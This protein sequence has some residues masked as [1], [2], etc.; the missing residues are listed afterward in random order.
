MYLGLGTCV[1][2]GVYC[3][4]KAGW[5]SYTHLAVFVLACERALI[6][7]V[8]SMTTNHAL[9]HVFFKVFLVFFCSCTC[10]DSCQSSL[11]QIRT[12][13]AKLIYC[14]S[15]NN[16]DGYEMP[17]LKF[18]SFFRHNFVCSQS[19]TRMRLTTSRYSILFSLWS[20]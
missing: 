1:N 8:Y 20:L 13:I 3:K 19:Y 16:T 18:I 9:L 12:S 2:S 4:R 11:S 6:F 5:C 17:F 14:N 7:S 15:R 10:M